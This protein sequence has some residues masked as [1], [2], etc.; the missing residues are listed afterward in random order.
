MGGTASAAAVA[1]VGDPLARTLSGPVG[2][3][4]QGA[5][6]DCHDAGV[7]STVEAAPRLSTSVLAV[8]PRRRLTRRPR[9]WRR[10]RQSDAAAADVTAAAAGKQVA[11]SSGG[12][13]S[14]R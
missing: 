11:D 12:A 1:A 8:R 3:T 5:A 10:Q 13:F 6:A 7:V 4:R 14:A 2:G 9:R